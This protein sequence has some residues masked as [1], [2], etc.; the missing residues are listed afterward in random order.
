VLSALAYE[1]GLLKSV[2]LRFAKKTLAHRE[3]FQKCEHCL[4]PLRSRCSATAIIIRT[5]I[6]D[7]Q[8]L[9]GPYRI[10]AVQV[11]EQAKRLPGTVVSELVPF[12]FET[13]DHYGRIRGTAG[14]PPVIQS[15]WLV[16]RKLEQIFC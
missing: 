16:Q 14:L 1:P 5:E 10:G 12:T 8:Q 15:T 2:Q 6:G 13:A 3:G 4:L 11:A 7:S 9:A